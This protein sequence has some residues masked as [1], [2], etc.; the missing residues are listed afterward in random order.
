MSEKL[1]RV[2]QELGEYK[3][4]ANKLEESLNKIQ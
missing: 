4:K 2:N 1:G 3:S